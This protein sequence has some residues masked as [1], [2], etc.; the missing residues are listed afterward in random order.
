MG[1]I[2]PEMWNEDDDVAPYLDEFVEEFGSVITS[3]QEELD[4]KK[5]IDGDW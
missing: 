3:F 1:V 5:K 2:D 4:G